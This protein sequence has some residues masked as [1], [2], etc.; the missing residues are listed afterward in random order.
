MKTLGLC[1]KPR[2]LLKK[3]DQN[4]NLGFFINALQ[5]NPFSKVLIKLFQKFAG[6]GKKP[7][8]AEGAAFRAAKRAEGGI[9]GRAPKV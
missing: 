6:T 8:R 3:F 4:F 2:E 7:G 5:H 9:G 1:P